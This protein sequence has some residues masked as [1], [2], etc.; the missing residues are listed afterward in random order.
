MDFGMND[1]RDTAFYLAKG[2]RVVAVEADPKFVDQAKRDLAAHIGSGQLVIEQVGIG[3][4]TGVQTFYRNLDNPDWSSFLRD[5]G[6]REGTRYEE[7]PIQCIR[8]EMLF[9]RHG[10]PYYLK[11]DIEGRDLSVVRG[12]HHFDKRPKYVSMEEHEASFYAELYALGYRGFKLVSQGR[13]GGTRCP[14]PAREGNHVPD[15]FQGGMSGP[16][17]DEAPG[18]WQPFDAAIERYFAEVR[19]PTN[20]LRSTRDWFDIHAKL[21]S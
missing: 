7:V 16:F 15:L 6:T 19:S 11:I 20:G 12:L 21:A 8:P 1:G 9:E 10:I 4:Q 18:E 13:I 5:W 14:E 2:F 17:G 3:D